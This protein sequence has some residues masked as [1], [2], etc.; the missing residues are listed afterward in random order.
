VN[1]IYFWI[2]EYLFYPNFTAKVISTIL[3]PISFIYSLLTILKYWFSKEEDFGLAIVSI[4]NLI[5]GGSGKTPITIALSSF[6][7]GSTVILRG[8]KRY[9]KGL[10]IV[11]HNG[12]ILSDVKESGDEA[13]EL[14][15]SLPY[16]NIIVSEN[17]KEAIIKAKELG[18]KVVF[19][20]DGFSKFNIKKFNI[21]LKPKESY[22]PFC[23]PSGPYRFHPSFYQSADLL[24]REDENFK[25]EVVIKNPTNKMVLLTAISKPKRLEKYLPDVIQKIYLPDHSEFTREFID[26]ILTTYSP[27][28]ILTTKKDAVKL[29]RFNIKLSI[30]ELTID[31]D[32]KALDKIDR[33]IKEYL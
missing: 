19:L 2:E 5:V 25:R 8:Y 30:L 33:Y 29:E 27:K 32:N 1:K 23:L 15:L 17:R 6:Y 4:G 3:L 28:S 12:K 20:D 16:S 11:S 22:R 10:I 26:N 31:I 24:L 18:S 9:S 21:L 13:M 7:K 14:A